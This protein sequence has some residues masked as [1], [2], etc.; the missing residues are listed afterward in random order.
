MS[1]PTAGDAGA[2]AAEMS[3]LWDEGA[4]SGAGVRSDDPEDEAMLGLPNYHRVRDAIRSDIARGALA[5]GVRLKTGDLVRRYGLSPAPIREA[6]SQLE[7]EG[8]VVISP[9]RGASVRNIDERFLRELNEIRVAL[10]SYIARL[11]A[12][13]ATAAQVDQL[14]AIQAEYEAAVESGDI[15]ALVRTNASFHTA[16]RRMHENREATRIIRR[17]GQFFSAMRLEWGYRPGRPEQIA[18]E[19]RTLLA[20]FRG[21]DGAAAERIAR[22]HIHHALDDLLARWRDGVRLAAPR[23]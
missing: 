19:H 6:L 16:I 23:P 13:S 5:C 4:E 20:A 21:R 11:V 15:S 3:N 10:D 7:A 12:E 22:E 2:G 14:E 17:H 9:N 18:Q 1:D 8:W